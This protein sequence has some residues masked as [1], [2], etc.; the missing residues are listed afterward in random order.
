MKKNIP[1]II[2]I[3]VLLLVKCGPDRTK[4]ADKTSV[5][6]VGKDAIF[7][8][9]N[10]PKSGED[11]LK[12]SYFADTVKFI[13]LE[14]NKESFMY[15]ITKLWI[16]DS[17]ILISCRRAGLLM[18]QQNGKFVRRIGN[19]GSGPGEY[20][21]IFNF[22]VIRDTIYISSTARRSFLRYKFDGT[23]CDEIKF[24]YQPVYFSTTADQKLAC[25]EQHQG[26]VLVYNKDFY[27]P[28]TIVV[29]YGVTSGRYKYV[30]G[31]PYTMTYFQKTNSGLLFHNYLNDTVWNIQDKKKEAAFIL[32]MKDKLLPF[33]K[34][35]EFCDGDLK[36]WEKMAVSY[37]YVHLM[38]FSSWIIIF[39]KHWADGKYNAIYLN[40]TKTDEIKKY[41]TSYIYDDIVSRQKLSLVFSM[42]SADYLVTLIE[43][44]QILKD[45]NQNK[46]N[47]K[48]TP[49]LLWLDQMKTI[50]ENDNPIL[51]LM[52]I[53]KN[54][55]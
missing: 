14:T 24:N 1:F 55:K 19:R 18:F 51:V 22:I 50:D 34:Q 13:P 21:S 25:Y 37:N 33:N 40:N 8:V 32:D 43:P 2:L 46:E 4:K 16:N 27:I 42:Y 12:T 53:K 11:T 20:A 17:V 38:P 41:N 54:L 6:S 15:D 26:I 44:S 31:D 49:S 7:H 52:K 36:R 23:F 3:T 48:G 9:L 39:Q 10:F 29:D 5:D 28:D 30:Y 47:N 35:V 45:L